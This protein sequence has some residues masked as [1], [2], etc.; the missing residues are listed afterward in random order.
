MSFGFYPFSS[1]RKS[2]DRR[3]SGESESSPLSSSTVSRSHLIVSLQEADQPFNVRQRLMKARSN[4]AASGA[5]IERLTLKQRLKPRFDGREL[6]LVSSA[7]DA[8][9]EVPKGPSRTLR[10]R[11]A[12]MTLQVCNGRENVEF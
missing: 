6:F 2:S 4:R 3:G 7:H 1:R 5:A 11:C 9:T 10:R 12:K 8:L